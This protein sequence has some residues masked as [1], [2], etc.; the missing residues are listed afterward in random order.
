MSLLGIDERTLTSFFSTPP[1]PTL[2]FR[3][4]RVQAEVLLPLLSEG[5]LADWPA[6]PQTHL[7]RKDMHCWQ[8]HVCSSCVGCARN[9]HVRFTQ[10]RRNLKLVLWM[11]VCEWTVSP[12]FISGTWLLKC[13][14]LPPIK[15]RET[16]SEFGETRCL[17]NHQ[18]N[19]RTLK[20]RPNSEGTS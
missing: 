9:R 2:T 12:L 18:G 1:A 11:Q 3:L 14:I 6:G 16:K 5:S 10:C 20:S 19:T 17:T 15:Y 13:Y 7:R 8:L 4:R